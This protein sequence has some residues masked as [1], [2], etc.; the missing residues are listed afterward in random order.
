M[1]YHR[2]VAKQ[3]G[4]EDTS[5][6]DLGC[7]VGVTQRFVIA[8]AYRKLAMSRNVLRAFFCPQFI[9]GDAGDASPTVRWSERNGGRHCYRRRGDHQDKGALERDLRGTYRAGECPLVPSVFLPSSSYLFISAVL[10]QMSLIGRV[11][12]PYP[13]RFRFWLP[14]VQVFRCRTCRTFTSLSS[15]YFVAHIYSA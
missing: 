8:Q 1:H 10:H 3:V 2:H 7:I 6:A 4:G 14:L 11:V 5:I 13:E 12:Q 15:V 9:D